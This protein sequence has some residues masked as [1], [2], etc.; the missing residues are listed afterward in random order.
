MVYKPRKTGA[1][2]KEAGALMGKGQGVGTATARAMAG[3]KLEACKRATGKGVGFMPRV[4]N[5][6]KGLKLKPKKKAPK[7]APKKIKLIKKK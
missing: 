5:V 2:C 4:A 1:G 7:K 6:R 3:K